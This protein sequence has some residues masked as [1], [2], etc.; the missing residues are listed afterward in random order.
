[1]SRV[2]VLLVTPDFLASDFIANDEL[3]RLLKAGEEDGLTILWVAVRHSLCGE[4]AIAADSAANNPARPLAALSA[5]EQDEELV[6]FA[7]QI[8]DAATR[9]IVLRP[10]DSPANASL[11]TV[12]E[13]LLPKQPFEPEIILIL[14][15]KF[16]GAAYRKACIPRKLT[17]EETSP[18]RSRASRYSKTLKGGWWRRARTR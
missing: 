12:G 17:A 1:M 4:T 6:R 5:S 10:A 18:Q 16:L 8:L 15:G 9:P 13:P 2:A 7:Q 11:Q 3:P 14:G